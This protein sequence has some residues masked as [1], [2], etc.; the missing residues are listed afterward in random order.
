M[1][2]YV[3]NNRFKL[4]KLKNKIIQKKYY[5]NKLNDKNNSDI[6]NLLNKYIDNQK[7]IDLIYTRAD[8]EGIKYGNTN[9]PDTLII[10]ETINR[11]NF[12]SIILGYIDANIDN[13]NNLIDF[14][15][16]AKDWVT[17]N[18]KNTNKAT[19]KFFILLA[20]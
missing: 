2:E 4:Y 16:Y 18:A 7:L 12:Y 5:K 20:P 6:I 1:N 17:V 8:I 10:D 11:Y 14:K 9:Y 19:N 13:I 3:N 15:L